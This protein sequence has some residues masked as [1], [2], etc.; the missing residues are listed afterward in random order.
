[1]PRCACPSL[2]GEPW[3]QVSN[4][5]YGGPIL[6]SLLTGQG[7]PPRERTPLEGTRSWFLNIWTCKKT[8]LEMFGELGY[9]NVVMLFPERS[10]QHLTYLALLLRNLAQL[11]CAQE[12][13]LGLSE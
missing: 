6:G 10:A 9:Y 5:R 8:R 12:H 4:D 13:G 3:L 7:L 11:Y 2:V 1:M